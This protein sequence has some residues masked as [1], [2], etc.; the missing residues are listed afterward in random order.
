MIFN[1]H[2]FSPY[3]L[4]CSKTI[5]E[6]HFENKPK[7]PRSR[8]EVLP[9]TRAFSARTLPTTIVGASGNT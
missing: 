2:D 9:K 6:R 4:E 1:F 8:F 3:L 5:E 7:T